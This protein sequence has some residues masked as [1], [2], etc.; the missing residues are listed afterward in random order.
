DG[1]TDEQNATGCTSWYLD[2]D[3][4]GYGT[5]RS[6]CW[7]LAQSSR[8]YDSTYGTDC[9][10]ARSAVNPA[11]TEVCDSSDRDE[12]C[13]GVA[14]NDDP[15]AAVNPAASEVCDSANKDEDC[16]GAADNND[17]SA[18][19][20]GKTRYYPDSDKDTYGSSSSSGT[21]YCD[22]P[23]TSSVKYATSTTDCN[24]S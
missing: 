15:S 7:C 24:D 22:D 14:D 8:D 23:S 19:S 3:G 10:D 11:A 13:D 16:D 17:S 1:T 9:D 20:G 6:E 4:D 2:S 5:T 12:D 21:L 18:A